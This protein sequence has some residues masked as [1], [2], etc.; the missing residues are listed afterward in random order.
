MRSQI[1]LE[2][3]DKVVKKLGYHSLCHY[4]LVDCQRY[5]KGDNQVIGNLHIH[6]L[7]LNFQLV[8]VCTSL[9]V[10]TYDLGYTG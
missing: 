10:T 3:R 4:C 6:L 8:T 2:V 5:I 7:L 1:H 9:G